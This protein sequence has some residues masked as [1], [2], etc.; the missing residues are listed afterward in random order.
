MRLVL[1]YDI[2]CLFMKKNTP[3]KKLMAIFKSP[4]EIVADIINKK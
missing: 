1:F 2:G 3:I 4:K